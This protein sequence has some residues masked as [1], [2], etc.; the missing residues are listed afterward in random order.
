MDVI[1]DCRQPAACDQCFKVFHDIIL[2]HLNWVIG[3][4]FVIGLTKW[5]EFS[6][7]PCG[8]TVFRAYPLIDGS[9]WVD[10]ADR[11]AAIDRLPDRSSRRAV[12]VRSTPDRL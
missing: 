10:H 11:C 9:S 6:V 1:Q 2:Y 5:Q 4:G 8:R 3:N 12:P 7:V